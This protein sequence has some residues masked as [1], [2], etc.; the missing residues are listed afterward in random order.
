MW[1]SLFCFLFLFFVVFVCFVFVVFVCFV[2]VVFLIVSN[3]SASWSLCSLFFRR[4]V[5]SGIRGVQKLQRDALV[6]MVVFG[7]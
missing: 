2:F 3:R 5:G 6:T 4:V 7:F 1:D